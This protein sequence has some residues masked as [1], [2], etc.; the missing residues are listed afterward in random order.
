MKKSAFETYE[1]G[2]AN[3]MLSISIVIKKD[4]FISI[5]QTKNAKAILNTFGMSEAKGIRTPLDLGIKL[6]II[7]DEDWIN[8]Q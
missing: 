7:F 2:E 4:G 5:N 6:R 8:K 1:L 3:H